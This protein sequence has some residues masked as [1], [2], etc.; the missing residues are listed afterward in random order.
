ML[1]LY[2]QAKLLLISSSFTDL[3][4]SHCLLFPII[5]GVWFLYP[6]RWHCPSRKHR[7]QSNR[8]IEESL[9]KEG[10]SYRSV[11]RAQGNL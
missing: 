4:A 2:S 7:A 10:T 11:G 6:Y 1:A 3:L 5:F 8:V 9:M